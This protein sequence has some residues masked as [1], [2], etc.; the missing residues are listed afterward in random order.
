ADAAGLLAE[1][2]VEVDAIRVSARAVRRIRAML[3]EEEA[4]RFVTC[5]I[6]HERRHRSHPHATE[7]EAHAA[8]RDATGVDPRRYET[9]LRELGG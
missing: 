1:F 9:V 4:R 2:D 7:N 6:A 8:A 5:A 3:G